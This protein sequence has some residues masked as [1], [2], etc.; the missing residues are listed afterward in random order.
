M[1]ASEKKSQVKR[2]IENLEKIDAHQ[3]SIDRDTNDRNRLVNQNLEIEKTAIKELAGEKPRVIAV[4]VGTKEV[5][6][7]IPAL[8]DENGRM[9]IVDLEWAK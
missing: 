5:T 7:L 3:R 4:K 1:S 2:F 6:M 9:T 8:G